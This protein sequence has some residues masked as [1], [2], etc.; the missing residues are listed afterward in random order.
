MFKLMDKKIITFVHAD[1]TVFLD[2][3]VKHDTYKWKKHSVCPEQ[4]MTD[5][6]SSMTF[7]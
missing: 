5:I 4:V 2:C 6:H 7:S 1:Y 3:L